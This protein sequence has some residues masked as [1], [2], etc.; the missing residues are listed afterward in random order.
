MILAVSLVLL[1]AA[2]DAWHRRQRVWVGIL[3]LSVVA[4]LTTMVGFAIGLVA[5]VVHATARVAGR[6]RAARALA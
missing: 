1:V 2:A 3:L 4:T 5:L 6:R